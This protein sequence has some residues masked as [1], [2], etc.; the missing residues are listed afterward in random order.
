MWLCVCVFVDHHKIASYGIQAKARSIL[1]ANYGIRVMV[2]SVKMN[3]VDQ[4]HNFNNGM[5]LLHW[6]NL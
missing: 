3:R 6:I 4:S 1:I 2:R 5:T